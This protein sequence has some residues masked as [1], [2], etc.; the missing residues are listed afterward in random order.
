MLQKWRKQRK[1]SQSQAAQ[2]LG[3]P[4]RTLQDWELG[5]TSPKPLA[6]EALLARMNLLACEPAKEA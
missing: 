2:I 6:R 1:L 5:R 3:V 4:V